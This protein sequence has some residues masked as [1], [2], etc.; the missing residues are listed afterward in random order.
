[1]S[2]AKLVLQE[3]GP[4]SLSFA[5]ALAIV[6]KRK[7]LI[8]AIIVALPTVVGFVVSK[9]PKIY[10]A[11]TTVVIDSTAPQYLG[12]SFK[13]VVDLEA[14]WWSAQET[15]Q[16]ELKIVGSHSQALAVT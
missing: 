1:M 7:W 6:R 16:T 8:L 4:S 12:S 2:N 11:S 5:A 15:L 3:S 10:R 14:N 13:D 9:Q